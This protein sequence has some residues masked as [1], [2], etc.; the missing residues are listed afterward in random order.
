MARRCTRLP[1]R[2]WRADGAPRRAP[3]F[4]GVGAACTRRQAPQSCAA[5]ASRGA[6]AGAPKAVAGAGLAAAAAAS[7]AAAAASAPV[8]AE[9]RQGRLFIAARLL[10]PPRWGS[11]AFAYAVL[12]GGPR[13]VGSPT[14]FDCKPLSRFAFACGMT[15][16][17][18][19][20]LVVP[21][22][23]A[24]NYGAAPCF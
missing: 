24:P 19:R 20:F 18:K 22:A 21:V 10:S 3:L 9:G 4:S 14:L 7:S 11:S 15:S 12:F 8:A 6:P 23:P 2:R 1:R 16:G 5:A 17:V 13:D